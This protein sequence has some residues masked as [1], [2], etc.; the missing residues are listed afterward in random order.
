MMVS[1]NRKTPI[2]ERC[3]EVKSRGGGGEP[4]NVN[5]V[6]VVDKD[7]GK[8]YV[9]VNK[10]IRGKVVRLVPGDKVG[11]SRLVEGRERERN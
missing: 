5:E 11:W 1:G 10:N 3:K 8:V 7:P 9:D 6:V 2:D 4:P